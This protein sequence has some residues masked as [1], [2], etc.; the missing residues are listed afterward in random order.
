M[1]AQTENPTV[2]N[3]RLT[4]ARQ[5]MGYTQ[6]RFADALG[7]PRNTLSGYESTSKEPRYE[8]L[9]RMA[10]QL[11]VSTDWLLGRTDTRWAHAESAGDIDDVASLV[12]RARAAGMESALSDCMELLT[13]AVSACTP[14]A[15]T[16]CSEII[17]SALRLARLAGDK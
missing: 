2:F 3:A 7:V 13:I 10:E 12:M 11:G 15:R 6:Q 4:Q 5:D 1:P 9:V 8:L 14:E 17:S 16:A